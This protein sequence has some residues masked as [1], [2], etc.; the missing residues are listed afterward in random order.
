MALFYSYSCH[1]FTVPTVLWFRNTLSCV[2]FNVFEVK[3]VEKKHLV[4]FC[5][6]HL[7]L[8]SLSQM[9]LGVELDKD[10]AIRRGDW[11]SATLSDEQVGVA[12]QVDLMQLNLNLFLSSFISFCLIF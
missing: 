2:R 11:E 8:A 7:G 12:I 1:H 5:S 4:P 10:S 3:L 6:N 9:V